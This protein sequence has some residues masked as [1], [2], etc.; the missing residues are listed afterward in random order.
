MKMV[1]MIYD[2]FLKE[3]SAQNHTESIVS[4]LEM[5]MHLI[6]EKD[7]DPNVFQL[8]SNGFKLESIDNH[9]YAINGIFKKKYYKK[10]IQIPFY[11]IN[12]D[13]L[14]QLEFLAEGYNTYLLEDR[15]MSIKH[16]IDKIEANDFI[17]LNS[18]EINWEK[19]YNTRSYAQVA[20]NT[21]VELLCTKLNEQL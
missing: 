9:G 10:E 4:L 13:I 14:E 11:K 18:N 12:E 8:Q 2:M 6:E 21:T 19:V 3:K 7:I 20:L 17:D 5:L 16:N 1:I 15:N